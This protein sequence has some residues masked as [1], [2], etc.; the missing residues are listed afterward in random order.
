MQAAGLLI[1][2]GMNGSDAA[3]Y[4]APFRFAMVEWVHGIYGITYSSEVGRPC[5]KCMRGGGGTLCC[6]M[7]WPGKDSSHHGARLAHVW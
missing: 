1:S 6:M 2:R 7:V 5:M 4:T 3:Q